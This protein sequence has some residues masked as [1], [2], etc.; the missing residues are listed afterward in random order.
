MMDFRIKELWFKV[1]VL[2]LFFG[3]INCTVMR[4]GKFNRKGHLYS[5]V[6]LLGYFSKANKWASFI[7]TNLVVHFKAY[8]TE[9]RMISVWKEGVV[10]REEA[11]K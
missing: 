1:Q 5:V 3:L 2:S 4:L 8:Y 11:K 6:V 9:V 10:S 7:S